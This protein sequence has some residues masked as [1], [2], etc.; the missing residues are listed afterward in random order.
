MDGVGKGV[1]VTGR[2][3]TIMVPSRATMR[4]M[5]ER[6]I[7]MNHSFFWGF[8]SSAVLSVFS[9]SDWKD[10]VGDWRLGG[11]VEFEGVWRWATSGVAGAR[12]AGGGIVTAGSGRDALLEKL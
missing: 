12:I 7:M 2:T 8:Q 3:V 10:E 5:M 1:E 6:L 11:V 9:M 4:E